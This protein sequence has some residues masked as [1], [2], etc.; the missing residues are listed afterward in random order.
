MIGGGG[1]DGFFS[2]LN[3][4]GSGRNGS[5]TRGLSLCFRF[6]LLAIIMLHGLMIVSIFFSECSKGIPFPLTKRK[7]GTCWLGYPR[8]ELH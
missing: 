7:K 6:R 1:D 2:W 5:E 4:K 8:S 3:Q